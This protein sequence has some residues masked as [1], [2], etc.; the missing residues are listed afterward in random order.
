MWG[1]TDAVTP[2]RET[3][4]YFRRRSGSPSLPWAAT[5]VRELKWHASQKIVNGEKAEVV[6][7][8]ELCD[9]TEFKRWLLGFGQYAVVLK[10]DKLSDEIRTELAAARAAYGKV[11]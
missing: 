3:G 11:Q 8:F 1:V 6:A 7:E 9:T 2:G 4:N 10:P 5:S